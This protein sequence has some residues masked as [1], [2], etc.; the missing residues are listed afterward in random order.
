MVAPNR[1][2]EN[3]QFSSSS[4]F[5]TSSTAQMA[6]FPASD[7]AMDVDNADNSNNVRGRSLSSSKV[8]SRSA[9]V[10]SSTLSIPYHERM[11]INNDIPDEDSKNPI[12]SSQL[13]YKDNSQTGNCVSKVTDLM[14]PMSS[15]RVSNEAPA[16]NT[17]IV[18]HVDNIKDD[19]INIQ[20]LYGPNWPMEPELWDG[21]FHPI[22]LYG[23]LEHLSSDSNN[24]KES[25]LCLA[26]YIE[27][28]KIDLA[29]SN[30]IK[31]FKDISEAA[32]KFVSAIYNSGWDSFFADNFKN[33]FRQK[34]AFKCTPKVNLSKLKVVDS[35][36]FYFL[37]DL[38]F[39]FY[40]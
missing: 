12:D 33:S 21:N 22:S 6:W 7:S 20:L 17:S 4:A 34:L 27:D 23:S 19:I 10:S 24:I 16:L 28:K 25:S 11:E 29:K 38:F 30:N 31:E 9:S 26:K 1:D 15:Q 39:L 5:I 18:P 13:S 2:L 40:F 37:F 36:Y 35:N 14:P 3:K 8:S 32:W